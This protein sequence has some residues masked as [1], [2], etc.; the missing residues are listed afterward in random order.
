MWAALAVL[1]LLATLL[2][3]LSTA[4][5]QP[6]APAAPSITSATPGD[7]SVTLMWTAGDDNGSTVIRWE[8]T[9]SAAGT[10]T[11]LWVPIAG[12]NRN[13]S[14]HT[15]TGLTNGTEYVFNVRAVNG[16]GN[17]AAST[18]T[19]EATA[20]PSTTPAA[21]ASLMGT[22]GNSEIV[23]SWTTVA[24]LSRANGFSAITG[25]EVRQKTGDSDYSPWAIVLDPDSTTT[26]GTTT[27]SVTGLTNGTAYQFQVRARNANGAGAA[28][29]TMPVTIATTPGRPRS[30]TATPGNGQV[31]LS[32]TASSNGGSPITS[33]QFRLSTGAT[34]TFTDLTDPAWVTIP[35][36]GADTTSYTAISLN[37]AEQ[38]TFQVRAV[39]AIGAGSLAQSATVDPGMPPGQP[40]GLSAT[41]SASS[42]TL[43]WTPPI[44]A[45]DSSLNTGGSPILRY[46]YSQKTGDGDYGEWM[47]IPTSGTNSASTTAT[48]A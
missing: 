44:N 18:E 13:T 37:N 41:A 21:P 39:N 27:Y 40:T 9:Y 38:Y 30:L 22:P 8:Y 47:A 17:G 23:L 3:P 32:W 28:G 29:E 6:T 43:T 7:G 4:S 12:S 25:Y 45:A 5:A 2:T 33:W 35:G 11:N 1:A 24:G 14:R 19:T 48:D 42:V 34:P 31:A 26:A 46:E 20:T 10:A 36:S 15:V 16:A